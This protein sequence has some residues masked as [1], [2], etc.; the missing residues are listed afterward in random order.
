M[1][2]LDSHTKFAHLGK[3]GTAFSAGFNRRLEMIQSRI[4]LRDKVILDAGC[5]EGV[6]LAKFA[7]FT[8]E[9]NIY[10]TD[11]DPE[12]AEMAKK[13]VE[14]ANI[15]V[16]AGESLPFEDNKFD[17]VFSNEVVEH[18]DDDKLAVSEMIRVTKPGGKI[19][20][21]TPNRGWPFEQ[22]GIF[23]GGK[24]IWGNIPLLPWMPKFI[25]TRFA[26]HVRNYWD[27]DLRKLLKDQ[28]VKVNLHTHIFPGFD[29]MT[30][31]FG[32]VGRAV[33]KIFFWLEK[34][35]LNWFG[36][37]HFVILEKMTT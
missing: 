10:G 31:R 16:S 36:I 32:V 18:V 6:W 13:V 26:P 4:D 21:F 22:H 19:V 35:P 29:G 33:Q 23:L 28:P 14:G 3:P 17:I 37:S 5:G 30:R 25:Y 15:L 20:I 27:S 34:T 9:Q 7:E 24:Y 2:V 1:E 12:S 8:D 11:I